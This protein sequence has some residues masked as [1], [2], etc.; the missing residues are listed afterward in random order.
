MHL[1]RQ[2]LNKYVL[3]ICW[4]VWDMKAGKCISQTYS[5]DALGGELCDKSNVL[6]PAIC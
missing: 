4:S 2:S 1:N 3:K 5:N 6:S